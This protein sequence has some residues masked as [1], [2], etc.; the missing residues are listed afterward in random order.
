[1]QISLLS[2]HKQVDPWGL[3]L[4]LPLPSRPRVS[5]LV[6]HPGATCFDG[7]MHQGAAGG[8]REPVSAKHSS[9]ASTFTSLFPSKGGAASPG[10][11]PELTSCSGLGAQ[12][13][14]GLSEPRL[15]RLGLGRLEESE[16][17]LRPRPD[18]AGKWLERVESS[19][20]G[21]SF[22]HF[23]PPF[24]VA[25]CC[26]VLSLDSALNLCFPPGVGEPSPA[27]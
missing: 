3:T 10:L 5:L 8:G 16:A 20:P 2:L 4:P 12:G 21:Q 25:R 24:L 23:L 18:W 17:K 19:A 1:M 7:W 14:G 26:S 6:L 15:G 9:L 27:V 13:S 22:S 11:D